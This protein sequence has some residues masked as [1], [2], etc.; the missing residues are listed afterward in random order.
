M[1]SQFM[2]DRL[3]RMLPDSACSSPFIF[4]LLFWFRLLRYGSGLGDAS[5]SGFIGHNGKW[6]D[7][8]GYFTT[9]PLSRA[10]SI[11]SFGWNNKL[12]VKYIVNKINYTD[13]TWH[14]TLQGI[15][16]GILL[17]SLHVTSWGAYHN[18]SC[19]S[20]FTAVFSDPLVSAQE[21]WTSLNIDELHLPL[22]SDICPSSWKNFIAAP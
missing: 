6:D 12:A 21:L 8:A 7:I 5:S 20:H 19:T 4:V 17:M 10:K 1:S 22:T 14:C 11:E 16:Q 18:C 15:D 9:N 13:R 3:G 2:R